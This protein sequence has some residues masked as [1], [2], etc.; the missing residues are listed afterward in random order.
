MRF[1]S[2]VLTAFLFLLSADPGLAQTSSINRANKQYELHAYNL[3]IRSYLKVLERQPNSVEALYKLAD[4]YRHLNQLEEAALYYQRAIEAGQVVPEVHFQYGKTLKGLGKYAD[5]RQQFNAYAMSYPV[6]GQQFA[7]SCDFAIARRSEPATYHVQEE[8]INTT[9]SEF[10]PAFYLDNVVYNSARIDMKRAKEEPA[11]WTGTANNQLYITR[12]DANDFLKQPSFLRSEVRNIYNEG[13]V[14]YSPDGRW[15]AITKNNFSDGTRHLATSG[16]EL[17]LYIAEV[18]ASGDWESPIPFPHNGSGYSTGFARFSPDGNAIYYASDRAD[19]F[20]GFDLYV[21]YRVGNTWSPPENLG[22]VVN[23]VGN[24]ITPFFDGQQLYFASDWHMGFGG[25]DI[26]TAD[27]VNGRFASVKHM[28]TG[29][30]SP[31]DD[32][33]F[34]Y[35]K[36][37]NVGYLTSNRVGGRGMEDLY[38]IRRS[39][40]NFTI[41]VLN[42]SDRSPVPA[43]SINLVACGLGTYETDFNGLFTLAAQQG[44]NCSAVVTKEGFLS[45]SFVIN[46]TGVNNNRNIEV[47]LRK[48]GEEYVGTVLSVQTSNP[49]EGVSIRAT[50]SSNGATIETFTDYRGQYVLGLS[51][52]T[53]YIIRYSKA[54]YLD[55]S[56]TVRTGNGFDRSILGNTSITPSSTVNPQSMQTQ[57]M[58]VPSDIPDQYKNESSI[59]ITQ[60]YAVQL[61]A[62][63]DNKSVDLMEFRNKLYQVGNVYTHLERGKKKIRLGPF[64]TR[65]EAKVALQQAKNSGYTTAFMVEQSATDVKSGTPPSSQIPDSY[66]ASAN[67]YFP[68]QNPTNTST[69]RYMI[70]LAAYQ[71]PQ[72]F[73]ENKVIDIGV[74]EKR[75]KGN[76][77]VML[78]KGYESM[79]LAANALNIAKSRGFTGAFMVMEDRSGNLQ[80]V[81]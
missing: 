78:L 27:Q 26:F 19:G 1:F 68:P 69:A 5:A 23:T 21:S 29:I 55:V 41:Q 59:I 12:T 34:I 38:R 74:L 62:F 76:L 37:K 4:S 45:E 79:D 39:T 32:Y 67:D 11:N 3:A 60:G 56:R 15:V 72:Y 25:Y 20:G 54:G 31:R 8:Y 43:A 64:A 80:R 14:A 47:L 24:E 58:N 77:T 71:N 35:D 57:A 46:T 51:P 75:Q 22:A 42:A 17:S 10:G 70:Q 49:L 81:R 66:D 30:N 63:D 65:N 40:D 7:K 9:A 16:M 61:A 13:P 36:V 50:N 28:G 52:Y 2:I 6:D 48:Q 18:N 53:T 33:G 44:V 73:E